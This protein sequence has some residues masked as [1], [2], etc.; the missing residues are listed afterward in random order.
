MKR[1][2]GIPLSIAAA[3]AVAMAN[4][5]L[6]FTSSATDTWQLVGASQGMDISNLVG[7]STTPGSAAAVIES[8]WYY[9]DTNGQW[10]VAANTFNPAQVG[11]TLLTA[12]NPYAG[13]WMRV[14]GNSAATAAVSTTTDGTD[15]AFTVSAGW[16]LRATSE[17]ISTTSATQLVKYP[18][19]NDKTNGVLVYT[20]NI[21]TN[22][23][24]VYSPNG[25]VSTFTGTQ[26]T[27]INQYEGFWV[28][29]TN[30]KTYT[31]A[32]AAAAVTAS[33]P[34]T[35]GI[36]GD[37]GS[38]ITAAVL[39]DNTINNFSTL[40]KFGPETRL[41]STSLSSFS[42]SRN[43]A[44]TD[45]NATMRASSNQIITLRDNLITA[46]N[47]VDDMAQQLSLTGFVSVSTIS[48]PI[49]KVS[50]LIDDLNQSVYQISG[51]GQNKDFNLS[52][53]NSSIISSINYTDISNIG[54]GNY[55]D[56]YSTN[57]NTTALDPILLDAVKGRDKVAAL[58][59]YLDLLAT[60]FV[61]INST[62]IDLNSSVTTAG[63]GSDV[64]ATV[65][66]TA[67]DVNSSAEIV[68]V[69]D[70]VIG[71]DATDGSEINGS[72][73]VLIT[74]TTSGGTPSSIA[75][76]FNSTSGG[77]YTDAT[78]AAAIASL[79]ITYPA[80]TNESVLK[81]IEY[82][83][84]NDATMSA[85]INT[86][87]NG[88]TAL[89]SDRNLTVYGK[90]GTGNFGLEVSVSTVYPGATA[91]D[92]GEMNTSLIT[93]YDPAVTGT[94]QTSTLTFDGTFRGGDV[95]E[96]NI[97]AIEDV[98]SG[99]NIH[100]TTIGF[101][102]TNVSLTLTA[103]KTGAEVAA[104][105]NTEIDNDTS[106]HPW[107][108]VTGDTTGTKSI[109]SNSITLDAN[110]TFIGRGYTLLL[111]VNGNAAIS[112]LATSTNAA[113][114]AIYIATATYKTLNDA[115]GST[116]I[117]SWDANASN[118]HQAVEGLRFTSLS[119]D[120]TVYTDS[121]S[122]LVWSLAEESS[123]TG[124]GAS[125]KYNI[126]TWALP[127][128]PELIT[129]YD[130]STAKMSSTWL[131]AVT[132]DT[133]F[134]LSPSITITPTS[135]IDKLFFVSKDGNVS[136]SVIT[137]ETER[138]VLSATG[139]TVRE[140][141]STDTSVHMS[142]HCVAQQAST[143]DFDEYYNTNRFGTSNTLTNLSTTVLA[144]LTNADKVVADSALNIEWERKVTVTSSTSPYDTFAN[145][146]YYCAILNH[147]GQTDWRLPTIEEL[148]SLNL[149]DIEARYNLTQS[150]TG[151]NRSTLFLYDFND[152][153]N[154]W[155]SDIN[156]TDNYKVI[157]P[158][159]DISNTNMF[160]T[161]SPSTGA[162]NTRVICVRN[163]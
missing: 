54:F 100:S 16:N 45:L 60:S 4:F 15:L 78:V 48:G 51:V 9:N 117:V 52:E 118:F 153:S 40:L 34:V 43:G 91:G 141:N 44:L 37:P 149:F 27:S 8:A 160:G 146:E 113:A 2:I 36:I 85:L 96:L 116:S 123:L 47:R 46:K 87:K 121:A 132:G 32:T 145:A 56:L 126:N 161:T 5:T 157:N 11:Y 108:D 73:S 163:Q 99:T 77:T 22:A 144:S 151:L 114:N 71:E 23:F 69:V 147:G 55:L 70:I 80:D 136:N 135:N 33:L 18:F 3:S 143:T 106:F 110:D 94:S 21:A 61:D 142:P 159:E 109:S 72:H 7:S 41:A 58:K 88:T 17:A 137:V 111:T 12:S 59:S 125:N 50:S 127:T 10:E 120:G 57:G 93:A 102:D 79:G 150:S 103:D 115:S 66:I 1:L 39:A 19:L 64:N 92:L 140:Y 84:D 152:S 67:P 24:E 53:A 128:I 30:S 138:R 105:L 68:K 124:C 95:I 133:S 101:M 90:S 98:A 63:N 25:F 119:V 74:F 156:T 97:S 139:M 42:G 82:A 112:T 76:D 38:L 158:V 14:K 35:D 86:D 129:L 154:Y 81:V 65:T 20:Y 162:T 29:V 107:G 49:A 155:S 122:R 130:G 131:T 75:L 148:T 104:L 13:V 26:F 89:N 83:I 28:K 31:I 134:N 6:T 62:M